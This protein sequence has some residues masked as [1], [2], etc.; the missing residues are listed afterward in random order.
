M[1]AADRSKKILEL[2]DARG[3]VLVK[4]LSVM[5]QVTEE[6]IRRDLDK[7][8]ATNPDIQ[9]I[10][11]GAYRRNG[12][13]QEV[14][15][16]IRETL[17]LNEKRDIAEFCLSQ[18]KNGSS[19]MLDASS[20]ALCIASLIRQH[21]LEV[22]VITNSL[23]IVQAFENYNQ[24]QVICIGGIFRSRSNSFIGHLAVSNL[25]SYHADLSFV[26]C[27][28][29]NQEFGVTDHNEGE[30][31][32]R[33]KMLKNADK[34]FLIADYTKLGR[35]CLNRIATFDELRCLVTNSSAPEDWKAFFVQQ[36]IPTV[37]C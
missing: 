37:Y 31:Q 19:I 9:R 32:V 17:Y 33:R 21:E 3:M 28:G 7:I 25:A 10:H 8:E 5:L 36:N 1:R 6:T 26:S 23:R 15:V 12:L 16:E 11:G 13:D 4:D 34:S 18:I 2:L 35:C 29:A 27:S 14:P 30:A 20:T 24:A 22:S